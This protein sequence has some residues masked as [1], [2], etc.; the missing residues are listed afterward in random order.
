MFGTLWGK[1]VSKRNF[2]V[3]LYFFFRNRKEAIKKSPK[4]LPCKNRH[5]ILTSALQPAFF[6]FQ[7]E[8]KF[9]R[10]QIVFS[11]TS[12]TTFE[13]KFFRIRFF[14]IMLRTN[15][16]EQLLDCQKRWK[17]VPVLIFTNNKNTFWR[18][19]SAKATKVEKKNPRWPKYNFSLEGFLNSDNFPKIGVCLKDLRSIQQ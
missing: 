6:C 4:G 17:V 13:M 11:H 3:F 8:E 2:L 16:I 9:L 5:T 18:K 1:G 10:Y 19:S 7:F 14:F 12:K 15:K